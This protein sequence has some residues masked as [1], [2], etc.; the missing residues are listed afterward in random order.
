MT[1]NRDGRWA[2]TI[3]GGD[4]RLFCKSNK[5][6]AVYNSIISH[7]HLHLL[8]SLGDDEANRK[9]IRIGGVASVHMELN[10][11]HASKASREVESRK[12]LGFGS[13]TA[14]ISSDPCHGQCCYYPCFS[15][16][17]GRK[18]FLE[19][20]AQ[21]L[22]C[23]IFVMIDIPFK[24]GISGKPGELSKEFAAAVVLLICVSI[25]G[26]AR[27]WKKSETD[28]PPPHNAMETVNGGVDL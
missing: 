27:Y 12:T 14:L 18:L 9:L 8:L 13:S 11:L 21:M 25:A 3:I 15:L 24:F 1:G 26:F 28:E 20:G 2:A 22:T 19:G 10:D 16:C 4:G 5:I 6:S 23:Q 7:I 17:R